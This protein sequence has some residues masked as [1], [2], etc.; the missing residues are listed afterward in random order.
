MEFKEIIESGYISVSGCL[1][2]ESV[3]CLRTFGVD[4]ILLFLVVVHIILVLVYHQ[5]KFQ[6]GRI[7]EDD[8]RKIG[9]K[10]KG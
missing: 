6:C 7:Q 8:W 9:K 5:W 10:Y 4:F 1:W 2:P 3:K